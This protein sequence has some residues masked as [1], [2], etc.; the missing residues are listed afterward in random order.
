MQGLAGQGKDFSIYSEWV[1]IHWR[2]L[3]S[4]I[5]G[6]PEKF[7]QKENECLLVLKSREIFQERENTN[8]LGTWL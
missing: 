2:V 1:G 5:I 3:K 8:S 4:D 6:Y 7:Q